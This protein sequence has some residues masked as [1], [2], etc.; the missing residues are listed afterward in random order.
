MANANSHQAVSS[1]SLLQSIPFLLYSCSVDHTT[2][3]IKF[4]STICKV[5]IY[6][7]T[8]NNCLFFL[9]FEESTEGLDF[10]LHTLQELL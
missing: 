7:G 5:Y 2:N 1:W 10:F 8:Q 9:N 6:M 3:L 4:A